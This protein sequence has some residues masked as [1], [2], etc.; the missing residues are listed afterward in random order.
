MTIT[1]AWISPCP[2]LNH[3]S[4]FY[5]FSPCP[6]SQVSDR[7][8]VVVRWYP[9]RVNPSQI[10]DMSLAKILWNFSILLAGNWHI[11][12]FPATFIKFI[13]C[14][15][16]FT[17]NSINCLWSTLQ[18]AATLMVTFWCSGL[19]AQECVQD[20]KWKAPMMIKARH[21]SYLL[22]TWKRIRQVCTYSEEVYGNT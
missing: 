11:M 16:S 3:G 6:I 8:A 1:D 4:F 17:G 15:F 5:M 7:A 13:T 14:H 22:R 2:F 18:N 10:G 19:P 12:H 9:A 21:L 20:L